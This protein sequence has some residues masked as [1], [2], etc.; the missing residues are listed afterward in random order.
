[1]NGEVLE[2]FY[3]ET[4]EERLIGYLSEKLGISLSDAMDLYY[5]S[6]LSKKIHAGA[7]DIQY[8]DYH[9]LAAILCESESDLVSKYTFAEGHEM[10]G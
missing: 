6:R 3:Q 1:M 8:L 9:V 10:R 2:G 7:E 5:Q 4:L